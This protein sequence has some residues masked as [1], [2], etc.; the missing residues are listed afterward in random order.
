MLVHVELRACVSTTCSVVWDATKLDVVWAWS[1][2]TDVAGPSKHLNVAI[3]NV[4]ALKE[5]K[6][7]VVEEQ[8]AGVD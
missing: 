1:M 6:K 2:P 4:A 7:A 5:R 3:Q 8:R